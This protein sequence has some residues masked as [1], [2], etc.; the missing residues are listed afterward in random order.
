ME[1][2]NSKDWPS[3]TLLLILPTGKLNEVPDLEIL[4]FSP[5]NC[6]VV[7]RA[8]CTE[9]IPKIAIQNRLL[10]IHANFF[11]IYSPNIE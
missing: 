1:Y 8:A 2:I 7:K 3:N 4:K 5:E 9:F 11:M 6:P 10:I